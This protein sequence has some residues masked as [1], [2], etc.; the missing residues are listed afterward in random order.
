MQ[1]LPNEERLVSSNQDKVVLT[2]QRINLS[3]KEWGRSYQITIFLENISSIENLYKSNVIFVLLAA[4][5]FLVGIMTLSEV[6]GDN[7][8]LTFGSFVAAIFFLILWFSSRRHVVT[9]ASNGGGKLNFT[10]DGMTAG[11]VEDFIDKVQAAQAKRITDLRI[12]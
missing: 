12:E 11:Q 9:I 1:L 3:D 10:V 7:G 5:S 2:N 8:T 4:V 6:R